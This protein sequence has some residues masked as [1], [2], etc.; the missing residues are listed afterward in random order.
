MRLNCALAISQNFFDAHVLGAVL[1]SLVPVQPNRLTP[2]D[3]VC[4]VHRGLVNAPSVLVASGVGYKECTPLMNMKQTSK[5]DVAT[6]YYIERHW[7]EDQ[8]VHHIDLVHLD[9]ADVD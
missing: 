6:V 9:V 3:T 1:C 7:L 8:D 5:V 4:P 2:V